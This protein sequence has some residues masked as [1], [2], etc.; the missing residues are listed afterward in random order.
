[1]EHV[2]L[3]TPPVYKCHQRGGV[4]HRQMAGHETSK[5]QEPGT[6]YERCVPLVA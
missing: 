3:W 1:V 2:G 4:H 6:L 5:W